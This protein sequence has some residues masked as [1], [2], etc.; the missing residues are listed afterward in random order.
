MEKATIAEQ[1]TQQKEEE[2]TTATRSIDFKGINEKAL[3]RFG[4]VI[5]WLELQSQYEDR[6]Y[7]ALKKRGASGST[8]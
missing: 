7:V 1:R 5:E 8:L 4:D 6:G 3:E 2:N